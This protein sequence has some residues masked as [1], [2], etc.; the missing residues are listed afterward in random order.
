MF[1]LLQKE[2]QVQVLTTVNFCTQSVRHLLALTVS[3]YA[4]EFLIADYQADTCA[5]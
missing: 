5:K 4:I 2:V 1:N 3:R